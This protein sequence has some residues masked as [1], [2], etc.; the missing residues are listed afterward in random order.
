[1]EQNIMQP[2]EQALAPESAATERTRPRPV[3]RPR[4]DIFETDA[5]ITLVLEVPG[6]AADGVDITLEKRVLNIRARSRVLRPE[7]YRPLHAEYGEG[8]YERSF[9]LSE[10]IDASRI[11]AICNHGLLT[12]RLPKAEQA[13][14]RQINVR[15]A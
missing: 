5:G 14:P 4:A 1:M 7:A 9:S 15:V 6:V 8:D 11:E 10:D 13:Q 12:L 3:F 2:A